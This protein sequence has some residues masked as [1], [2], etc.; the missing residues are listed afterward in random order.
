MNHIFQGHTVRGLLAGLAAGLFTVAAGLGNAVAQGNFPTRAVHILVPFV[1]G[2]ATDLAAR[3]MAEGMAPHL[4]VPVVIENKPGANGMIANNAVKQAD[5]DG[6]LMVYVGLG[7]MVTLPMMDPAFSKMERIPPPQNDFRIVALGATYDILFLTGALHGPKSLKELMEKL[8]S[9]TEHV[10]H[11]TISVGAPTDL[12]CYYL[13][14]LAKGKATPVPYKGTVAAYPDFIGG[15]LT[16]AGDTPT[17]S[18]PLIKQGR[19]RGLA[20]MS[21]Q[22]F[23]DLPDVPTLAEAGVPEME[24]V[25]W[26][27]WAALYARKQT[28]QAAIDKLNDSVRRSLATPS[29]IEKLDRNGQRPHGLLTAKE[30]QDYWEKQADSWRPVLRAIGALATDQTR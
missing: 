17:A 21:K 30:A 5:A 15:L 23:K 16:F 12:A 4:G 8:R 2:G 18:I 25:E 28:A 14:A 9:P 1:A 6:H 13:V 24:N 26:S 20:V 22:R 29:V 27:N 7:T 11:T 19:L 10:T 3:A